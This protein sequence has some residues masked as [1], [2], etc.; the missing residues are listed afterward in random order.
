MK[1]TSTSTV[2]DTLYCL[3][4]LIEIDKCLRLNTFVT[5]LSITQSTFTSRIRVYSLVEYGEYIAGEGDD[6]R[7]AELPAALL[8]VVV[9]HEREG[10]ISK[11]HPRRQHVYHG[12]VREVEHSDGVISCRASFHSTVHAQQ[13]IRSVSEPL[14]FQL[15]SFFNTKRTKEFIS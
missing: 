14:Y 5:F 1:E 7:G 10:I 6:V 12:G 11:S 9:P 13:I 15:N 4:G 8:G 2:L 3:L